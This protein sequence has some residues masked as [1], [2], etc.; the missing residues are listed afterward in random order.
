MHPLDTSLALP[1]FDG[2]LGTLLMLV[3]FEKR[4]SKIELS[5]KS[6]TVACPEV[7]CCH[8]SAI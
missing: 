2:L 4:K 5:Q 3:M 8:S 1:P 7:F 6:H